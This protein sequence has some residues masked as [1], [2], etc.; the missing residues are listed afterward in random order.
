LEAE[1]LLLTDAATG[2]DE[3]TLAEV[4][5]ALVVTFEAVGAAEETTLEVVVE[6]S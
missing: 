6:L 5:T 3:V 2:L 1:T 4:G